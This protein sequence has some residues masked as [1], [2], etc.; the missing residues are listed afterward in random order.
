METLSPVSSDILN[1]YTT[2]C[3]SIPLYPLHTEQDY[4]KA[5]IIL[6][7]LLDAGGANEN[8]PLARLVEALGVFIGD[9]ENHHAF[10]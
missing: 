6:N 7:A 10:L 2:L 1:H 8:H 3:E 5:V 9:Y 4:D